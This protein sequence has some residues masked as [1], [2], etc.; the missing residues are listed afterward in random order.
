MNERNFEDQSRGNFRTV[1]DI[2]GE[3]L[4]IEAQARELRAEALG[5][6]G[7]RLRRGAANMVQAYLRNLSQSGSYARPF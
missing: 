3:K 6:F 7:A 4:S 5:R 1:R 2:Y